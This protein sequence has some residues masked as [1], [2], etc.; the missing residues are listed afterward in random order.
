MTGSFSTFASGSYVNSYIS[1]QRRLQATKSEKA[2]MDEYKNFA[3]NGGFGP[4]FGGSDP[5]TYEEKV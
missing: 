3:Q 1:Q 5:Q 4:T 2:V